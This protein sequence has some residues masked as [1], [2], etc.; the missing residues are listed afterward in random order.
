MVDHCTWVFLRRKLEVWRYLD[1]YEQVIVSNKL[2]IQYVLAL[3][4]SSNEHQT[5]KIWAQTYSTK[6]ATSMKNRTYRTYDEMQMSMDNTFQC[7]IQNL[8]Y[9]IRWH[10]AECT[11]RMVPFQLELSPR[12]SKTNLA[13]ISTCWT[14]TWCLTLHCLLYCSRMGSGGEVNM[15]D[16]DNSD[17]QQDVT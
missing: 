9:P 16:K 1:V 7:W 17:C 10:Q 6:M 15:Q 14:T 3:C 13:S 8:C 11:V 2:K 5:A 4:I 12:R